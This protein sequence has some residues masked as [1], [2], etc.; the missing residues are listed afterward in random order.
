MAEIKNKKRKHK[1]IK[2]SLPT[3]LPLDLIRSNKYIIINPKSQENEAGKK[4]IGPNA[5]LCRKGAIIMLDIAE[6]DLE[7]VSW[8]Q[9]K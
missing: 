1:T 2:I 8:K 7:F 3:R 5:K 4:K 6:I 9:I